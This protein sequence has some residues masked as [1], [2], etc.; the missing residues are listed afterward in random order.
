M[1]INPADFTTN[2]DNPY[3]PLKPGT[4]FVYETP[5]GSEV[6]RFAVT[7]QTKVVD[8][9]TCRVVLD[10]SYVDGVLHERTFDYF[11]QDV[12]GNVLYFGE[13]VQNFINGKV[14]NS[15][16][17]WLA[18]VNGAEPGIAMQ[19]APFV[20]QT[21]AQE[22]APGIAQDRAD[23]V[24]ITASG[25][26]P[27]GSVASNVLQTHE[28]TPLELSL[29]EYKT[30]APG[31]GKLL[32][33]SLTTGDSERLVSIEFNGTNGNDT[34]TG[35]I[36]TDVLRG[37][38]GNDTMSGLGGDDRLVGGQGS[39]HE[40]GGTG[41]DTLVGGLGRDFLTGG[42]GRD[43][44]DFNDSSESGTTSAS[45]DVIFD[46]TQGKDHIDLRGIDANS[47]LAGNNA[48][49]WIGSQGFHHTAGEL[50]FRDAGANVLVEGDVNGDG[51]ADFSVLVKN[52]ASV[53]SGDF[54][55]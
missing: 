22:N 50:H 3:L 12:N 26:V 20:G 27:Y 42:T 9:V 31:I 30:Y 43:T 23:V 36:G 15:N 10:Q 32:D 6:V 4:T 13:D 52:V 7:D 55:L 17:S 53:M 14:A 11:A 48:F 16:G 45:R 24:S 34:I 29:Q 5:D 40:M 44:F 18:G 8:G 41:N 35:N 2:I 19:A 54:L 49:Q 47:G 46:F 39:D 33:I 25:E 37:F 21:Y 28:F 51:H 1:P 38:R